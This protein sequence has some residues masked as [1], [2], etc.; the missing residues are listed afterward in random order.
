MATD[1]GREAIERYQADTAKLQRMAKLD[2]LTQNI[3]EKLEALCRDAQDHD[4]RISGKISK[5]NDKLDEL[6]AKQNQPGT[7][8]VDPL[9]GGK[10]PRKVL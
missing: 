6:V 8:E 7:M 2:I 1:Q 5:L 3:T 10:K 4:D 9:R